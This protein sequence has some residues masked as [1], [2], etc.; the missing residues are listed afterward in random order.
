MGGTTADK[1]KIKAV[2]F[3]VELDYNLGVW[4]SEVE[5]KKAIAHQADVPEDKVEVEYST[6]WK[7]IITVDEKENIETVK[8]NANNTDKIKDKLVELNVEGAQTAV[9]GVTE[10]PVIEVVVEVEAVTE[11]GRSQAQITEAVAAAE[12]NL[13]AT[14]SGAGKVKILVIYDEP[15][16][17]RGASG[18]N[19]LKPSLLWT[20]PLLITGVV[21][22]AN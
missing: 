22:C 8:T 3:K 10:E 12:T 20:F 2:T 21:V 5:A 16:N 4:V 13:G 19:K 7:A 11:G 14:E 15:T 17:V 9:I 6:N 18:T 1:V